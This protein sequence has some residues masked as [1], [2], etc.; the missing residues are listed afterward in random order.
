MGVSAS[1]ISGHAYPPH[2]WANP[3][4]GRLYQTVELDRA[5]YALYQPSYTVH[6]TNRKAFCLQTEVIGVPE[7]SVA[8]WTDAQVRWIAHNVVVPQE[9]WLRERGMTANIGN[10]RYHPDTSGSASEYWPGRMG[11]AEWGS[12]HG[13]CAH[14][15]AVGNDHWD[16]SAERMDHLSQYALEELGGAV[17]GGPDLLLMKR[18]GSW[19]SRTR[20]TVS[21][22][23]SAGISGSTRRGRASRR[24][25]GMTPTG[26]S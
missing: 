12:F 3:Y 18:H 2:L 21:I 13:L 6:W 8:T 9:R 17:P 23:R 7:V 15:D 1:Y 24:T 5:G 25:P 20:W 16:A 19:R 10:Y 4:D 22:R 11:D 26:Q 14:I